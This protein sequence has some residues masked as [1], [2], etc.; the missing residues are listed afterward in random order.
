MDWDLVG[1]G[2]HII[3]CWM[4][5]NWRKRGVMMSQL[6]RLHRRNVSDAMRPAFFSEDTLGW[7]MD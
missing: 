4:H 3:K 7:H 2:K 1:T 5:G 6:R